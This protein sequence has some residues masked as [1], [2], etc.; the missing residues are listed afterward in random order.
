MPTLHKSHQIQYNTPTDLSD[1]EEVFYC[2]YTGRI[3]RT[4]EEYINNHFLLLSQVWA[5][6]YTGQQGLTY[7]QAK[8]SEE[9]AY[10]LVQEL[11]EVLVVAI[12]AVVN[13]SL[14]LSIKQIAMEISELFRSRFLLGENVNVFENGKYYSGEIVHVHHP[15]IPDGNILSYINSNYSKITPIHECNQT[16]TPQEIQVKT[17][18]GS[19][20]AQIQSIPNEQSDLL[21]S[22]LDNPELFPDPNEYEYDV[23]LEEEI[24]KNTLTTGR[25]VTRC[26]V[27]KLSRVK[28]IYSRMRIKYLLRSS[29]QRGISEDEDLSDIPLILKEQIRAKYS[30]PSSYPLSAFYT[31]D[32]T[33]ILPVNR[34]LPQVDCEYR[35]EIQHRAETDRLRKQEQRRRETAE[36]KEIVRLEREGVKNALLE[37][38]EQRRIAKESKLIKQREIRAK[39]KETLKNLKLEEQKQRDELANP[40]EDTTFKNSKLIPNPQIFDTQL[41]VDTFS[42]AVS[43]LEFLRSP[44]KHLEHESG[45]LWHTLT[46]SQLEELLISHTHEGQFFKLLNFLLRSLFM[47][48]EQQEYEQYP[49]LESLYENRSFDKSRMEAEN[50]LGY[51]DVASYKCLIWSAVYLGSKLN[52]LTIDSSTISEILRLYFMCSGGNP[53]SV[54]RKRHRI[55]RRGNYTDRDNPC[56]QLSREH[57]DI[58]EALETKCV[59]DLS[60]HSKAVIL[61]T[62]CSQLLTCVFMRGTMEESASEAKELRKVIRA[63]SSNKNKKRKDRSNIPKQESV[64]TEHDITTTTTTTDQQEV[65]LVNI[66]NSFRELVSA[67]ASLRALLLGRDRY[68]M[69]YWVFQCLPGIFVEPITLEEEPVPEEVTEMMLHYQNVIEPMETDSKSSCPHNVIPEMSTEG[70]IHLEFQINLT[71]S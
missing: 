50:T 37:Q 44:G 25:H 29:L 59:F 2:R 65:G 66:D 57:G 16:E 17:E 71:F 45:M 1:S 6:Q 15:R 47:L 26:Q 24:S 52:E 70:K 40:V 10:K 9:R 5:C 39:E 27:S 34:D 56:L 38:K 48:Q 3:Y 20:E 30:L 62:L 23:R 41:S 8:K 54:D 69:R 33:W 31:S 19:E 7:L 49:G 36:K 18:N 11:P 14:R 21:V 22:A 61:D 55:M 60:E 64:A 51:P 53:H 12:L 67:N 68:H 35:I 28:G 13:S 43:I 32:S 42:R 63:L 4:Y 46:F 58:V